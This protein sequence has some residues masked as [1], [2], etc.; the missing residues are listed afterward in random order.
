MP[1]IIDLSHMIT[2]DLVTYPGL[3][4]PTITPFLSREDSPA[5]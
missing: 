2:V 3:P 1:R 5:R 4:A